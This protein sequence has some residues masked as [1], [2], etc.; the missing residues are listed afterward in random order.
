MPSRMRAEIET[1]DIASAS[2]FQM[3]N[4]SIS[5]VNYL[6]AARSLHKVVHGYS[7]PE[8]EFELLTNPERKKFVDMVKEYCNTFNL[9][10]DI[11]K[12]YY[13]ALLAGGKTEFESVA[14]QLTNRYDFRKK[15]RFV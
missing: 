4:D 11:F 14:L 10:F 2:D 9:D 12:K 1:T 13:N 8:S 7:I 6:K 5:R 3:V 15:E